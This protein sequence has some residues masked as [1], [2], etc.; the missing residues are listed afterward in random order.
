MSS[1]TVAR[2][3]VQRT[4]ATLFFGLAVGLT[5]A[6]AM[7][8]R[9]PRPPNVFSAPTLT[10]SMSSVNRAPVVPGLAGMASLL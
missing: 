6:K 5:L 9:A 8:A 1:P 2:P 3:G 10:P 4:L 7:S